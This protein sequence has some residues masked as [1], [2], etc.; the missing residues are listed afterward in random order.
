[1][2]AS[3]IVRISGPALVL[4]GDDIDTDRIMPARFLK[5]ITFEGLEAHVF[6]DDRKHAAERGQTHA[7]DDATRRQARVLVVGR[8]FG[9][10]SSRE[11]APQALRRWGI[12]AVVGPSFAEIFFGNSVMIGMPCVT[13]ADA[14]LDWLRQAAN[15]DANLTVDVDLELMTVT[16]AGKSVAA[17]MPA[18]AREALTS[19][20]W[21]GTGLLLEDYERVRQVAE[22]LPYLRSF[23]N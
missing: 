16:A 6:A 20:A 5:A 23:T 15:A 2:S 4:P 9:C 14:D 12:R 17:S 10:G 11:H 1:M 8:N 19:G 3:P 13:L 22:T 21:D 18:P 7:F